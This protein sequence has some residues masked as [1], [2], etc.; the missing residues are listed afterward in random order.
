MLAAWSRSSSGLLPSTEPRWWPPGVC[1][2]WYCWGPA[3]ARLFRWW[4]AYGSWWKSSCCWVGGRLYGGGKYGGWKSAD[5]GV[6]RGG[7][8]PAN[9]ELPEPGPP[10]TREPAVGFGELRLVMGPRAA[11]AAAAAAAWP[12]TRSRRSS[13][14]SMSSKEDATSVDGVVA[15][16]DE[17][18]QWAASDM[19]RFARDVGLMSSSPLESASWTL[20]FFLEDEDGDAELRSLEVVPLLPDPVP[21]GGGLLVLVRGLSCA[22]DISNL[23]TMQ[24]SS[25]TQIDL[26]LRFLIGDQH[27]VRNEV[28]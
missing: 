26:N 23:P 15:G 11:A 18:A 3:P 1:S 12:V 21:D 8:G 10:D 4:V 25:G 6:R 20:L 14:T 9:E 5:E 13:V 7:G 28:S 2:W 27:G 16:E 22:I 24:L 19:N 17:P